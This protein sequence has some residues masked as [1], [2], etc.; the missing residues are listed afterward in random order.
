MSPA[1]HHRAPWHSVCT[2]IRH[3]AGSE[4]SFNGNVIGSFLNRLR[5]LDPVF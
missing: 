4:G 2:A 1:L 5:V 3:A